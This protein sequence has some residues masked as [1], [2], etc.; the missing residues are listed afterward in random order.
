MA[1]YFNNWKDINLNQA[2]VITHKSLSSRYFRVAEFKPQRVL[3]RHVT[4]TER[5]HELWDT[6]AVHVCRQ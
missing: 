1:C 6:S 3:V 5:N 2:C 4:A